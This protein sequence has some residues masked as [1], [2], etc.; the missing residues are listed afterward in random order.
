MA[1]PATGWASYVGQRSDE[2]LPLRL[3]LVKQVVGD[4][5]LPQDLAMLAVEVDGLLLNNVHDARQVRLQPDRELDGGRVVLQFFAQLLDDLGRVA[6]G[7]IAFV[8]KRQ[9]RDVVP[10]PG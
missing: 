2:L 8:D 3:H 6:P 10:A 7:T 1:T 4:R 9:R 5:L